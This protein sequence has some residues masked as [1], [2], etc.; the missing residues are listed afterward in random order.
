MC[1]SCQ[2]RNWDYQ[3]WGTSS[4]QILQTPAVPRELPARCRSL[5]SPLM[6]ICPGLK[7]RGEWLGYLCED[8]PQLRLASP[9]GLSFDSN[10]WNVVSSIRLFFGYT[11]SFSARLI[12]RCSQDGNSFCFLWW[13]L[14][15]SQCHSLGSLKRSKRFILKLRELTLVM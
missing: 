7:L 8:Y 2:L 9:R 11:R 15:S 14:G 6:H 4:K 10:T 12:G 1:M 13:Q 3:R 5:R